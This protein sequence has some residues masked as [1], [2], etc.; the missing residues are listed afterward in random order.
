MKSLVWDNFVDDQ[1]DWVTVEAP[2]TSPLRPVAGSLG[3]SPYM[4]Q[5]ALLCSCK[6]NFSTLS[7]HLQNAQKDYFGWFRKMSRNEH[8]IK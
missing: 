2:H 5:C 3:S 1:C 7:T 8:K 6:L 4:I